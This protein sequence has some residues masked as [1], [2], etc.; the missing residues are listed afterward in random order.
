[1]ATFKL[2]QVDFY[3]LYVDLSKFWLEIT[4]T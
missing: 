2:T 4:C 3:N 1:V